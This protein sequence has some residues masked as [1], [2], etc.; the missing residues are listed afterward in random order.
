MSQL[1]DPVE[2][3]QQTRSNFIIESDVSNIKE[4]KSNMRQLTKLMAEKQTHHSELMKQLQSQ[5]QRQQTKV[6]ALKKNFQE[7]TS[8]VKRVEDEL[9]IPKL[10][11]DIDKL[12]QEINQ[13]RD[14]IQEG[15]QKV[16][17]TQKQLLND[18]TD[19]AL[20]IDE[21]PI[22]KDDKIRVLKLKLFH[23]LDVAL[24]NDQLLDLRNEARPLSS[25]SSNNI[26]DEL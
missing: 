22:G 15:I 4:I 9:N 5:L 11:Q 13:L 17:E 19:A 8:Q 24:Y 10:Q 26:W 16:V 12:V 14:T 21:E 2:L 23:S 6:Q 25:S 20:T 3:L 7:Q 1:N 18:D